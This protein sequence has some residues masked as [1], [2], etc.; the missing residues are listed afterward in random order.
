[1]EKRE[2]K[3]TLEI[4]CLHIYC[5]AQIFAIGAQAGTSPQLH[6][7]HISFE[8][9]HTH[10]STHTLWAYTDNNS[11]LSK[12]SERN[13]ELLSPQT[14]EAKEFQQVAES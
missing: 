2:F 13:P 9:T 8:N 4:F 7:S 5:S 10:F 3:L 14:N 1:M 12:K 11:Q 6:I